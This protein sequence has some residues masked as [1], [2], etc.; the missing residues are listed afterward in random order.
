MT[1]SACCSLARSGSATSRRYGSILGGSPEFRAASQAATNCREMRRIGSGNEPSMVAS[2]FGCSL[3]PAPLLGEIG[4]CGADPFGREQILFC[5]GR[6][7]YVQ[8][9][10]K[11]DK[12]GACVN[13]EDG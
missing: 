8:V 7:A 1:R 4:T 6:G 10:P 13:C 2:V 3:I 5:T 11:K 12:R 9:N